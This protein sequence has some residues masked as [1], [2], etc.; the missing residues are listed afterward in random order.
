MI[1]GQV[2]SAEGSSP[3][4]FT[5]LALLNPASADANAKVEVLDENGAVVKS[6]NFVIPARRRLS[7]LLTEYFPDLAG[8]Q[9][10]EGYVRV[11]TDQP[12]VSFALFGTTR[13]SVLSAIPPK[14]AP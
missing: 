11:T 14:L 12:L 13:L 8:R 7:Q 4:W 9:I 6:A 1:F 3:S 2:E 5:G 10:L